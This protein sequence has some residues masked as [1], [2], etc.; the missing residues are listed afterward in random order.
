MAQPAFPLE[1]LV[2]KGD[3]VAL[4]RRTQGGAVVLVKARRWA[5][6]SPANESGH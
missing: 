1:R 3:L 2:P 5:Q 4:Y 6:V